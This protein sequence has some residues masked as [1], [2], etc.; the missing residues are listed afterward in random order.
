MDE[1]FAETSDRMDK[2]VD[3]VRRELTKIRTGKA[4]VSLLDG[5]RLEAYGSTVPLRQVA[6]ISVPEARLLI[7]QPWDRSILGVV[8]KAILKS[9]LGL[10]PSNDGNII[11]V[12]IPAL[13]EERRKEM[14]RYVHKLAEE[15]RVAVRNIRRD[16]N[17]ALKK[18]KTT[19]DISEDDFHRAHD[20]VVQ[21]MTNEHIDEI[22]KA[23]AAKEKE[24]MEV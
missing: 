20:T 11:R 10:N 4:T 8:E 24:L 22:D 1:L 7:V 12:P 2:A 3:S 9:D 6:N 17:E 15:G 18:M 13:T 16:A 23:L 14:V 19:G 21:D 5:I